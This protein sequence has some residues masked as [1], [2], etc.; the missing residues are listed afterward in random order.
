LHGGGFSDCDGFFCR[1]QIRPSLAAFSWE[2][3]NWNPVNYGRFDMGAFW[4][5]HGGVVLSDKKLSKKEV[6]RLKREWL[7]QLHISG[8]PVVK[9]WKKFK[10]VIILFLPLK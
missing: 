2:H 7:A 4:N 10:M 3:K 5:P 6:S 9:W 1:C 8:S